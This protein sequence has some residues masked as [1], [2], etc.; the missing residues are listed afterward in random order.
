MPLCTRVKFKPPAP[1]LL[2]HRPSNADFPQCFSSQSLSLSLQSLL[3]SFL[4]LPIVN[5]EIRSQT[6]FS[7]AMLSIVFVP[8]TQRPVILPNLNTRY[9][10]DNYS[11]PI[12]DCPMQ[13]FILVRSRPRSGLDLN[14][15]S[16]CHHTRVTPHARYRS[17]TFWHAP[18][19]CQNH[20][21]IRHAHATRME[22]PC[23]AP[24]PEGLDRVPSLRRSKTATTGRQSVR[25][26]MIQCHLE[27][28]RKSKKMGL[29]GRF[30][31][32]REV[33]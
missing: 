3:F 6:M 10:Y 7:L 20:S 18:V 9:P 26:H 25:G 8:E 30:K 27:N 12:V 15:G 1:P 4:S 17:I 21:C 31:N 5:Q 16:K 28:Q 23:C 22:L 29:D 2:S 11:V 13:R 19:T 24:A 14:R 33:F 32:R